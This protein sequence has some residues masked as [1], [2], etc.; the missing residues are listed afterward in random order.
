MIQ[1]PQNGTKDCILNKNYCAFLAFAVSCFT[2]LPAMSSQTGS[3]LALGNWAAVCDNGW[4]CEALLAGADKNADAG[5]SVQ[6]V[7]D[8]GAD[9]KLRLTIFPGALSTDGTSFVP[10]RLDALSYADKI[11]KL[12]PV[13]ATTG[14]NAIS[15]EDDTA[16]IL[17]K[18]MLEEES[19]RIFGN[20]NKSVVL[21]TRGLL[22][23]LVYFDTVQ[24]R[25]GN[26]SAL[27]PNGSRQIEA[28]PTPPQVPIVKTPKVASAAPRILSQAQ[29]LKER[30][31]FDCS[32]SEPVAKTTSGVDY[33]RLDARTTLAI[34]APP[35]S[36]SSYNSFGR[37]VLIDEAGN[38]RLA[39]IER[40]NAQAKLAESLVGALWDKTARRLISFGHWNAR[41]GSGEA[42]V[43]DGETFRIVEENAT[44]SCA[45]EIFQPFISWRATVLQE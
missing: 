9:G 14:G 41:C 17:L 45:L 44:A 40:D 43:W 21:D 6:L 3:T 5:P 4:R 16:A 20:D 36:L 42:Y 31:T 23:V 19:F 8:G 27:L 15:F 7:R 37:I 13:L 25:I 24:Q 32:T 10:Q 29:L 39:Q 18:T 33:I 28:P 35:C 2:N 30:Q 34:I 11:P 12:P 26:Q 1:H 22:A 38:P